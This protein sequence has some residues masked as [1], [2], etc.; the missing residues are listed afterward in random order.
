MSGTGTGTGTGTCVGDRPSLRRGD[1]VLRGAGVANLG[2]VPVL[3]WG[4]CASAPSSL[5]AL[6]HSLAES[7][8]QLRDAF[9]QARGL[10]TE[11]LAVAAVVDQVRRLPLREHFYQPRHLLGEQ[12]HQ[13]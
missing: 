8:R 12:A 6:R 1:V 7:A 2:N 10:H 13:A 9:V 4:T 11:A 3:R 5:K